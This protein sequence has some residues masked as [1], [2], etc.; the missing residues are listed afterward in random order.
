MSSKVNRVSSLGLC[1]WVLSLSVS[2]G[3]HAEEETR[4][5]L[6]EDI[7]TRPSLLDWP[8]GPKEAL[9]AYGV[10]LDLSLAQFYQG[11]TAGDGRKDWQYGGKLDGIVTFD[12]HALG[13]WKGLSLKVH[14]ELVY[15]DDA[16]T[17]GAGTTIPEN[18]AMAFPRVGGDDY[19]TSIV[20]SQAFDHGISVSLGKFNMLDAAS[21]TPLL[22]GGGLDTFMH[23]GLA[24]PVSGVTPPYVI[25][26]LLTLRT[27][28][29]TFGLFIYDPRNAQDT[30]VIEHLFEDGVTFSLSTT[31]PI[32]LLDRLGFQNFR[33][34]YSTEEGIDLRDVPQLQLPPE[35]QNDPRSKNGYWYLSYSF[36]QFLEHDEDDPSKG[37]GIFGQVAVTDGNPNPLGWLVLVGLGGNSPIPTRIEDRWGI[38]Y[39]NYRMSGSLRSAAQRDLGL[40]Y[41]DEAGFEMFYNVAVTPWLLIT[42]DLQFIDPFPSENDDAVLLGLRAQLKF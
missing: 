40:R 11:V 21:R 19:N 18:T 5:R 20:L 24:A 14:Q 33:A 25:G 1:L 28:P 26:S 38:G 34:V 13:L 8:G 30:D 37:W 42:A 9:R 27:E 31:V 29:A 10:E 35:L 32:K 36:Q 16:L 3:V 17:Q 6:P 4:F 23:T 22:G 41:K 7:L 15:A 2:A 39:F 12:G